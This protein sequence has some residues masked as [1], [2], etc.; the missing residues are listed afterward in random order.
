MATTRRVTHFGSLLWRYS[1][2]LVDK[3]VKIVKK[4]LPERRKAKV[5]SRF[6]KK[7]EL[8]TDIEDCVV[9]C[10]R[11]S[12]DKFCGDRIDKVFA[13]GGMWRRRKQQL[14]ERGHSY[15]NSQSGETDTT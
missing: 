4:I 10:G 8:N 12:S 5:F 15:L 3:V 1:F 11:K 9:V 13:V 2:A 14:K 7:S 6:G